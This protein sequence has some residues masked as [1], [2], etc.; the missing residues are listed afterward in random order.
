MRELLESTDASGEIS[1]L[2]SLAKR[3]RRI[4]DAKLAALQG[5]V[6]SILGEDP[7]E[8]V[9]IFSQYLESIEMIR[10][11]LRRGLLRSGVPRR[12]VPRREG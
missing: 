1:T 7:Q 6:S 5:L 4:D 2:R 8:K 12:H 3:A 10:E 9:L 11:R